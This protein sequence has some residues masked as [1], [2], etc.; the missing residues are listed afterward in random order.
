MTGAAVGIGYYLWLQARWALAG[1]IAYLFMLAVA[2]QLFPGAR[3]LVLM[4]ALLLM[5]SGAHLLHVF[6]LGPADFGVRS[7]G[8]PKHLFVLPQ[9]TRSLVAW[10]MMFAAAT[11]AILWTLAALLVLRPAGFSTPVLWPAAMAAAS[12]VWVQAIG[13]T[14]FATPFARVPAVALAAVPL[15]LLGTWCGIYL[16]S[17][18]VT[19]FASAGSIVWMLCAFA[20]G[21]WGVARARGG[22]EGG[23]G[24]VFNYAAAALGRIPFAS[25]RRNRRPFRSAA[26]AQLWH[27]WRRNG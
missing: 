9:S 17:A 3:E 15:I 10:P 16:E 2:A 1:I 13:W 7:S 14:P 5:A 23:W 11:N 18:V 8:F 19:A 21:V 22:H 4:A 27:E 6:S 20:F 12:T 25:I 26:T 24:G